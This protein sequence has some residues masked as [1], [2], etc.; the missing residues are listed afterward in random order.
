MSLLSYLITLVVLSVIGNA[1]VLI[2][3]L[4]NKKTR[5]A[6]D[7]FI[8]NICILD[9]LIGAFLKSSFVVEDYFEGQQINDTHCYF[10]TTLMTA[11]PTMVL[12]TLV[13][14]LFYMIFS[15]IKK[16]R[17]EKLLSPETAF[18]TI[19][20]MW[21]LIG[22]VHLIYHKVFG[23]YGSTCAV[24]DDIL[25][26]TVYCNLTLMIMVI[27]LMVIVITIEFI[28]KASDAINL[29]RPEAVYNNLSIEI[30]NN[31]VD[32]EDIDGRLRKLIYVQ[33][34]MFILFWIPFYGIRAQY[35]YDKQSHGL[36][37]IVLQLFFYIIGYFR[38]AVSPIAILIVYPE[39]RYLI[40]KIKEINYK[41]IKNVFGKSES[42]AI[43]T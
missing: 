41:K 10:M 16:V 36:D 33:S 32:T 22:G 18:I 26:T 29:R 38:S 1:F 31:S 14:L 15:S 23:T 27:V 5:S 13:I 37:L 4:S 3:L 2:S 43:V 39:S 19:F 28:K 20:M 34:I 6:F 42:N 24:E 40:Q 21:F 11:A 17:L 25:S 12:M 8:I 9:F 35:M 30:N 7:S